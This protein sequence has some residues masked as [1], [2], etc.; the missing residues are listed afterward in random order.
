MLL[1]FIKQHNWNINEQDSTRK[2]AL[3]WA[4]KKCDYALFDFLLFKG[5]DKTIKEWYGKIASD[6]REAQENNSKKPTEIV[7]NKQRIDPRDLQY[8][9][10]CCLLI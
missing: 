3:H 8:I 9:D 10:T 4:S 7:I 6:Y 2:T 1:Y 5:A